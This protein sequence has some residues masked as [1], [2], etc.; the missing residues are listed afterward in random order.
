MW[1]TKGEVSVLARTCH[2]CS[3]ETFKFAREQLQGRYREISASDTWHSCKTPLGF[4]K[5]VIVREMKRVL[6]FG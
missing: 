2:P 5:E 6:G 1:E 3:Y 4:P